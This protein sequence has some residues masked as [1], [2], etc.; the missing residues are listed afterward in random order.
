VTLIVPTNIVFD[1]AEPEVIARFEEALARVAAAG[2]KIVRRAVPALDGVIEL[3]RRHGAMVTAEAYALHA[4]RLDGAEAARMD[5]RVAER[6]RGGAKIGLRDYIALRDGRQSLIAA[7]RRELGP[8]VMLAYPTI[9]HV[10]PAIRPLETDDKLYVR[11][12]ALTL[13]NTAL[14]NFL[15]LCGVSL[16]CGR[17]AH[18]LPVGFLLSGLGGA[19]AEVLGLALELEDIVRT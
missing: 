1:E 15:D 6:M 5:P 2:A 10:A 12:N 3:G 14:G 9:A 8:G 4:E 7:F 18:N 11:I 19:D 13:R 17:G 16:P